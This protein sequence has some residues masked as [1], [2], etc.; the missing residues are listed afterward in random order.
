MGKD[1]YAKGKH[2]VSQKPVAISEIELEARFGRD[3]TNLCRSVIES[4]SVSSNF[5]KKT[6][7]QKGSKTRVSLQKQD[8]NKKVKQSKQRTVS[9]ASYSPKADPKEL[10]MDINNLRHCELASGY[11]RDILSYLQTQEVSSV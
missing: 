8:L 9:E 6:S 2:R 11:H 1:Q 3:I 10:G 4:G 5:N 7:L